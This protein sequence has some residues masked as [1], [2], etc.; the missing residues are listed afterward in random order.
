MASRLLEI[1]LET[2]CALALIRP[3]VLRGLR[4]DA[5]MAV[6]SA[7]G[8]PVIVWRRM[9]TELHSAKAGGGFVMG[10]VEPLA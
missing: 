7:C 3:N 9:P 1:G 5:G 6:L 4:S 10:A 2:A 8:V